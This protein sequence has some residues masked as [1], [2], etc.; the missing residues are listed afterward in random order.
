MLI[1]YARVSTSG[2]DL[3]AQHDGLRVLGS[4]MSTCTSTTDSPVRLGRGLVSVKLWPPAA[5]AML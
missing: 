4:T 5:L 1:G 2:Q 3:A